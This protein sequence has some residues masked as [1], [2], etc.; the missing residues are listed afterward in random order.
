MPAPRPSLITILLVLAGAMLLS[1]RT[2][3]ASPLA[4]APLRT[5]GAA[6]KA[7]TGGSL[8]GREVVMI[9]AQEYAIPKPW[10]GNKVAVPADTV[11]SLQLI[12]PELTLN[13]SEIHLRNE[14]IEPLK[15]MAEAARKD[16]VTLVVDS[17]YR[18]ARY[19]RQLFRQFLEK[20]QKFQHISRYIAPPGYSEHSLG[21]V[22]DFAPS[23]HGFAKS[24]AY[25]WLKRHAA[26][27]G[28]YEAM[29]RDRRSGMPWEP[30]HWKFRLP[31]TQPKPA[32]TPVP[33][34]E[35]EPPAEPDV[36]AA[37]DATPSQR[38]IISIRPNL[39]FAPLPLPR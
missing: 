3:Q 38:T 6:S 5:E 22:I 25:T 19:Q 12:P 24:R 16:K 29:P 9:D 26:T 15:A 1:A 33:L 8:A 21:T 4:V 13:Q 34:P 7:A 39:T 30:W 32:P 37:A 36:A 28:F 2:L 35:A 27:F 14:V 18:S 20:G 31:P 10:A 17:G 23:S 11:T